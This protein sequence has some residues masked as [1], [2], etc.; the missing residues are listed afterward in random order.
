MKKP[1]FFN[2]LFCFVFAVLIF[3]ASKRTRI[4][5]PKPLIWGTRLFSI[6]PDY[7]KVPIG[8]V[9]LIIKLFSPKLQHG[10]PQS[11]SQLTASNKSTTI[12]WYYL[13]FYA[14]NRNP[15]RLKIRKIEMIKVF[16]RHSKP[17]FYGATKLFAAITTNL[18]PRIETSRT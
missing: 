9:F 11:T 6:V 3:T 13:R 14:L 1:F 4:W 18:D 16:S 12:W 15:L 7:Q 5:T 2:S 10:F 8:I 17:I